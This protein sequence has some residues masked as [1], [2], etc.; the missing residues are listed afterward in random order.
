M[1]TWQPDRFTI[2]RLRPGYDE[3]EVDAALE[4]YQA[5]LGALEA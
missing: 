2:T 1:T 4:R 5:E 3:Q